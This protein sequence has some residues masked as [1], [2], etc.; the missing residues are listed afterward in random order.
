MCSRLIGLVTPS[1]KEILEKKR[2]ERRKR[3]TTSTNRTEFLYGNFDMM[4]VS[5]ALNQSKLAPMDKYTWYRSLPS[6]PRRVKTPH[7]A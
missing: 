4:P 2:D 5:L 3:S 1:Q 6:P 7:C